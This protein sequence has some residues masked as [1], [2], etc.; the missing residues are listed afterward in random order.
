MKA[1][2]LTA[3]SV[4]A[5]AVA[6]PAAAQTM[7]HPQHMPGMTMPMP[8]AKPKPKPR[9]APRRTVPMRARANPAARPAPRPASPA[10][11]A[12]ACPL[13]HAAMGHCTPE[14]TTTEAT[15]VH[16]A[17][18]ATPAFDPACP[19]EHAA[20]G[21]CVPKVSAPAAAVPTTPLGT[22]LPAG[23]APA[24]A[25]PEAN[26][27]D[28]IW[29]R[30]AMAPARA[31]LRREHGGMT[32]SQ[33]ML[34]LAEV[35][36]DRGRDGYRWDGEFWSG[37]DINRLTLKSEGEG[38]FRGSAAGEV[39]ALY[40]RAIGPYFNLQA[41]LRQDFSP[42]PNRTYAT[43][44]VEGLAPYWFD[45]EGALFLSDRGDLLARLEG[46]YDQ[47]ITQRLIL[48]PRVELNLSA[49]DVAASR[50][51]SGLTDAEAGLRLRYEIVREFAPYV[52][53]SWERRF[54][55]TAR[56]ARADGERTGGV[57][58]VAGIRAW[59]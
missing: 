54:G 29:G 38:R 9:A 55:D 22:A 41:G 42:G 58:L 34:N 2:F 32:V 47:R 44:G 45:V 35:H 16:P 15:P 50:L 27:A 30:D 1:T 59:F 39:Q 52:G 51:G 28:R 17:P 18:V 46:Y 13:D 6:W 56:F 36:F 25:A 12:A 26:Y 19:P 5:L 43:V 7:D 3:A 40:S 37:G 21:H 11:P 23:N 24:P 14:P 49:Q 53:V 31:T 8:A 20:M 57:G 48:Q 10:M 33:L 4:T